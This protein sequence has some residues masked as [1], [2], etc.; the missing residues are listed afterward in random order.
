ML[1]DFNFSG[2]EILVIGGGEESYKKIQK[3][4][5]AQ[6]KIKVVS[7]NFTQELLKLHSARR[8]QLLKM[9]IE[10]AEAFMMTLKPKP[11]LVVVATD[12]KRLNAELASA[13]KAAGC[14]VYVID[15]PA[16]SDFTLPAIADLGEVKIA[17]STGGKSPAM[18]GILRRRIEKA[19]GEE[20]ILHIRLQS[21][22]RDVLKTKV[23]SHKARKEMVYKILKSKEVSRLLKEKRL[24]EAYNLALKII[25]EH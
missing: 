8:I 19:I 18:A 3:F 22:I 25:E 17:I 12:N 4:L 20:D 7:R 5:E 23:S 2:K 14:M 9:E 15:N 10:N 6:A 24:D 13:A 16:I 11:F 1:I 21:M